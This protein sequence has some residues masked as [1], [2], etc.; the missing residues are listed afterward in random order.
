VLHGVHVVRRHHVVLQVPG[1]EGRCLGRVG[2]VGLA[3]HQQRHLH[4]CWL[5]DQLRRQLQVVLGKRDPGRLERDPRLIV[6]VLVQR[7]RANNLELLSDG[8]W[9]GYFSCFQKRYAS[10][11]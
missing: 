7:G 6:L 4:E 5:L 2:D 1:A 11:G 3:C 9:H 10:L 8:A